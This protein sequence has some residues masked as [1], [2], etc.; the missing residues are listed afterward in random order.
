MFASTEFPAQVS[1]RSGSGKLFQPW[2]HFNRFCVIFARGRNSSHPNPTGITG[3]SLLHFDEPFLALG[4]LRR[5]INYGS[6]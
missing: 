6:S 5:Y 3:V 2:L 1:G 4:G